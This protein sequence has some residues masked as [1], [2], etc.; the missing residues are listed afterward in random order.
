MRH[1]QPPLLERAL[2][3]ALL[4]WEAV[5]VCLAAWGFLLAI[6]LSLGE[7]GLGWDALNHHIY[8]GWTAQ[9]HRFD[10]DFL[11]A[12]Y[13]SFQSPYLYWPVY[14]MAVG[15]WNGMWAGAV[16]ASLHLI[17][18]WPVWMLARRCMPGR[19]VFDLAM[20][21]LA[22]ALALMSGVVLSAFGSSMNDLLAAAPLVWAV[23]LAMEPVTRTGD[24]GP[25]A[26][27]RWVLLSGLCAGLAVAV[28]LS[29]G[30]LAVFMPGLWLLGA[31]GPRRRLAA[32]L[33]GSIGT[34]AGFLLGY[35]YWG[36]LLWRHFGN[37]LFPFYDHWFAPLRAWVGWA[38]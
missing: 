28:K 18:V 20:R 6:P 5:L 9:Q 15:G 25:A 22:V 35:G 32:V 27:R 3:A 30:P 29:N 10:R 36:W 31:R 13:Q 34:L 33:L 21:V 4:R 24:P 26:A 16:L 12:G 17:A 14:R 7:L 11:G 23:A 38:G 8:L 1:P 37:P 19:T 2:P